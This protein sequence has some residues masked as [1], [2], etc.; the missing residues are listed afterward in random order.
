V[1][2]EDINLM[3]AI[4]Q[5]ITSTGGK[6]SSV[7]ELV[8]SIRSVSTLIIRVSYIRF[9]IIP[10]IVSYVASTNQSDLPIVAMPGVASGLSFVASVIRISV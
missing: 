4:L 8:I 2:I 1:I 7:S 10:R 3:P 9:R 5:P 6:L